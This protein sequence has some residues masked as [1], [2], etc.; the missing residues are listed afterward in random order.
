M[1]QVDTVN[2]AVV[3]A[4]SVMMDL[5]GS[6]EKARELITE[7]HRQGAQVIVFPE[8]FLSGYPRGM[9]FGAVVG[10]RDYGGRR[11][12]GRY[13]RSA[14]SLEDGSL[15]TLAATIAKTQTY[16]VM[17]VI[18]RAD[19]GEHATLYGATLYFG[20]D[21]RV[22]AKHRKLKPTGSE[23]L[24]WGEGDGSTLSVVDSPYGRLGG[25]ICWEN[26]MPLARMAMYAKGVDLYIAPTADA[27]DS[28]QATL[29][30]IA[31]EGRVF[32][33]ACNQYVTKS[34]YPT[35][36]VGYG[37]LQAFPDEVCR[38]GSA[39]V[40]PL[41]EYVAGPLYHTEGILY[42]TLDLRQIEESRFD[43]DVTGHYARPDV[44]TLTVNEAPQASV[45]MGLASSS[46]K[47][48]AL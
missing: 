46:D 5:N 41:G 18:E 22:L 1:R 10:N 11:D 17:G 23:R 15:D 38:G 12:W 39:I 45:K 8:A 32:V 43:F 42:A 44:F 47:S 33:L 25:L 28:W 3:Q 31:C 7:A 35:D 24:I 21:G 6:I 16:V 37:D 26:Y 13:W 30:H 48:S 9:S 27:R 4:A 36:L 2:V 19:H 29:Q 14:V 34:D 20:P 40:N